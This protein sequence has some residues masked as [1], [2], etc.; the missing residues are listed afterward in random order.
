MYC[1][2]QA[3]EDVERLKQQQVET[4]QSA[5][6]L[7]KET[8]EK[9]TSELLDDFE[10]FK[11]QKANDIRDILMNFVHLQVF[12]FIDYSINNNFYRFIFIYIMYY[13]IYMEYS[14]IIFKTL[15]KLGVI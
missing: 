7:A 15:N 3:K 13:S 5:C 9:V 14:V 10:R 8:F 6:D 12:Y 11:A 1:T 2:G 4:A